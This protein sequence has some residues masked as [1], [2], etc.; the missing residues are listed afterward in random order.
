MVW[1]RFHE[2]IMLSIQ[3]RNFNLIILVNEGITPTL[4]AYTNIL[5]FDLGPAIYRIVYT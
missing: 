5:I 1:L 2:K 4:K 3:Q